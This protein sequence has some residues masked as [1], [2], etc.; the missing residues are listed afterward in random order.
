MDLLRALGLVRRLD[1]GR[2][3]H[4]EPLLST[5]A[6]VAS[7]AVA[8]YHRSVLRLAAESIEAFGQSERDLRAVTLGL[9]RSAIPALK[10][11]LEDFWRDLLAL[12]NGG[13]GVEDVVQVNLQLFPVARGGEGKEGSR[14]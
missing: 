11:K 9:P 5:P 6:E 13:G 1:S 10:A 14:D 2:W 7:L 4:A 12:G 8:N 3:E